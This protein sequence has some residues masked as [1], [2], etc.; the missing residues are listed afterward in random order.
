MREVLPRGED[1]GSGV[2]RLAD[3]LNVQSA[4]II[5]FEDSDNDTVMLKMADVGAVVAN[6]TRLIKA[7]A[8]VIVAF[9]D[10]DGLA[11]FLDGFQRSRLQ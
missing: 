1:K 3:V 7:S 9:N 4:Q 8:D 11:R 6:A 5:A 10:Q 2:K